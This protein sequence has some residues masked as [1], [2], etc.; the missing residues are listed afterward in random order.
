MSVDFYAARLDGDDLRP[1]ARC[2]SVEFDPGCECARC[3]HSLNVHNRNA[4]DLLAWLELG[5][6]PYGS[7]RARELAARCRRRLWPEPRNVDAGVEPSSSGRVHIGGRPPERMREY[8]E[9]LLAIA[10]FAG[11]EWV[12]WS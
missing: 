2:T 7:I 12:A 11:D 1:I 4:C 9:R 8:V 3:R 10:E 5:P 6:D